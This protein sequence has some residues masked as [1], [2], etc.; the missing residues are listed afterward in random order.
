MAKNVSSGNLNHWF[1]GKYPAGNLLLSFSVLV[2]GASISKVLLV[3]QHMGLTAYNIH[4]FIVHQ[5]TFLFPAILKHW[6]TY[7]IAL[8]SELNEMEVGVGMAALTQWDIVLS[9][10]LTLCSVPSCSRLFIL[11]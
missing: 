1:L 5:K 8:I 4:T 11:N 10:E 7:G 2:A 9:M 6:E 3:S